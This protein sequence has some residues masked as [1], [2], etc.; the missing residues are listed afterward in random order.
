MLSAG[1][2]EV[3]G[4]RSG[5]CHANEVPAILARIPFRGFSLHPEEIVTSTERDTFTDYDICAVFVF[6][7]VAVGLQHVHGA[8]TE[9]ALVYEHRVVFAWATGRRGDGESILC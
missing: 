3:I 1:R 9:G 5:S 2:R 8:V 4:L 6:K 7:F